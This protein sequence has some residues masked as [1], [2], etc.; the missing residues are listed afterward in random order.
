MFTMKVR[1]ASDALGSQAKLASWVGV[2]RSQATR[3]ADGETEPS[4]RAARAVTDLEFIIARA[5]MA[6][7]DSVIPDWL[8]GHNAFLDGATPLEMIRQGRTSE[9]L[10]AITGDESNVYG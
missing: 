3:W 2:S 8:N 1:S 7:D 5:R 9:V 10:D 6:W 4:G